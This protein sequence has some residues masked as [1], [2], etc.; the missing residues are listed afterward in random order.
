MDIFSKLSTFISNRIT[1]KY[2]AMDKC[3][4]NYIYDLIVPDITLSGRFKRFH[5]IF[6]FC[7]LSRKVTDNGTRIELLDRNNTKSLRS[8][9]KV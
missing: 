9:D 4:S 3:S 2:Y 1:E 6:I 8:S 7:Q 5:G